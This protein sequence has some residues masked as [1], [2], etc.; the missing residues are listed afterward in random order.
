[1]K[2]IH[3]IP[4]GANAGVA[5]LGVELSDTAPL[6]IS[7]FLS[8]P[9]SSGGSWWL[10]IICVIAGFFVTKTYVAFNKGQL[11][12]YLQTLLYSY[13]IEG[14]SSAFD[15]QNKL[16]IGNSIISNTSLIVDKENQ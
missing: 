2:K 15:R 9:L 14:Y 5:F 3:K 1:M 10:P 6:I 11:N 13:G 16:F 4:R 7:I 8:I 12:G